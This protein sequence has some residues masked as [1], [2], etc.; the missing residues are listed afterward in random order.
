[1]PAEA[2]S[3]SEAQEVEVPAL[4]LALEE[5]EEEEAQAQD[6]APGSWTASPEPFARYQ[7]RARRERIPAWQGCTSAGC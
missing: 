6:L 1:M 2:E 5:A 4:A 7:Y 3:E